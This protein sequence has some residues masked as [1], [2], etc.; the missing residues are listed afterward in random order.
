MTSDEGLDVYGAA[1]WGQFFIYQGF[2]A[3]NGWMHTSYGGDAIDEYAETIVNSKG[4][5]FYRYAGGLRPVRASS[6]RLKIKNG[7]G[8]LY[9][10][11]TVY[12]THHG[13]VVRTEDGRWI[14]VKILIDPVRA[15]EQSYLRTKTADY[16]SFRKTQELRTD[17]TNNTVYA[18]ADGNIA[19]FHGNFIPKRDP[20]F[21]YTRPVDGSDPATEWRGRASAR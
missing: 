16:A 7:G 9:R 15:L 21:D 3:H 17:T 11:F 14:T 18:D 2:N 1:T 19:Y 4:A 20:R 8:F 12:R 6:I 5:R 10:R 13:P